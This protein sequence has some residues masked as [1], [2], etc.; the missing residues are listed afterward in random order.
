MADGR[1]QIAL[2]RLAGL[3][4]REVNDDP[5][6]PL[7]IDLAS[8]A[9]DVGLRIIVEIAF[10]ERRRI[11]GVEDL[12]DLVDTQLDRGAAGLFRSLASRAWS[13]LARALQFGDA[14]RNCVCGGSSNVF[15][16]LFR[17]LVLLVAMSLPAMAQQPARIALLVGNQAYNPKV[18]PLK[19]P[20]EDVTLVGAALRSLGFTVTEIMDAD[21]RSMDA[22][23]KRHAAAVRRDGPGT[24]SLFYYSGHGAADP[25]TRTNYL[26]PVDVM[27]ADDADL[28]NVSLNLN[29]V[30][31][32]LRAQAPAATHY[33][34]FD[35][36][37]NELNLTRKGKKA[38]TDK[39]FVPIAYTP[40]V[41]VAYATAPGKTAAD[42]G[43]GGGPYA[44]AL[45]EEIVKPGIEALTMFRR[46]AL[47]VN[48]QIGQDPWLS[49]STLPEV[50]FAGTPEKQ[51]E[52]AFWATVKNSTNPIVLK[53]YLERYPNGSFATLA[54]ALIV[55]HEQR[56][57]AESTARF[58][59]TARKLK[60][61]LPY[62]E[63]KKPDNSV[64]REWSRFVG[65]WLFED[66]GRGL[67]SH[68]II[69]T[70]VTA[71]GKTEG[72]VVWG[73]P[74]PGTT[75]RY[76]FS[77]GSVALSGLVTDNEFKFSAAGASSYTCK[78]TENSKM[79][80]VETTKFAEKIR[81]TFVFWTVAE[82]E[83]GG[84]R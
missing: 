47:R 33:V 54:R 46:V 34:V 9:D 12:P 18:G 8:P 24:I 69:V 22:A 71:T 78:M 15:A 81:R 49:A 14:E 76:Q 35:A 13:P 21:Y 79:S 2:A 37:R 77:A 67:R 84:N 6:W 17:L 51:T 25:D 74:G 61:P 39:G 38:L 68:A 62:F 16:H 80:C 7:R 31:E 53:T 10:G 11:E 3:A 41:M 52:L 27:E 83:R 65:I 50:Y 28:W 5:E 63:V 55:Q 72:Y 60:L 19:N 30:V 66:D 20:H 56:L 48:R 36:C 26:I 73:P 43:S 4:D 1:G 45:A 64:R 58:M 59:E 29:N 70:S 42:G 32:G 44:H 23:I 75:E 40:G 57:E 82:G